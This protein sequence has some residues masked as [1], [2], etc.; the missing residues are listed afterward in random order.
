MEMPRHGF[1]PLRRFMR[2]QAEAPSHSVIPRP[3]VR[4]S[5]QFPM[6]VRAILAV[7]T[8]RPDTGLAFCPVL[9]LIRPIGREYLRDA[10][11]GLLEQ[12]C[13][14]TRHLRRAYEHRLARYG[15]AL[16]GRADRRPGRD[17]DT[18]AV[19]TKPDAQARRH[20]R[21]AS[22]MRQTRRGR[23]TATWRAW[24]RFSRGCRPPCRGVTLNRLL[25]QRNGRG[26]L[27]GTRYP[28]RR[29]TPRRDRR[30]GG[31]HDPRALRDAQTRHGVVTRKRRSTTPRSD[32][33]S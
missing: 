19:G 10:P 32:G 17:P 33:V 29:I 1:S 30:R 22:W 8:A 9:K 11:E 7:R 26:G 16:S 6:K 20:R 23:T 18:R 24:P 28:R 31:K 4:A 27:R 14:R 21:G 15:G 2:G 25:R 12:Y 13:I 3:A 5:D